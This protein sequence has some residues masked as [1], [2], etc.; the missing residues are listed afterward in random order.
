M[1]R[2]AADLGPAAVEFL[3]ERHL[4]TLATLRADGTP[5]VVAVGFTW[6]PEAGLARVITF[7]GSQKV[8]NAERGAYAAVTNVDGPRWLTLEGPATVR[9]EPDRV[10]EA[11]QRYAQRYRQ[12]K[13][14]PRRVVIEISVTRV[15]GSASLLG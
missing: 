5:H 13:P 1:S 14:N 9:R 6:D 12:P 3:T 7:E 10:R 2:T 8:R 4:G 15:L 11:E